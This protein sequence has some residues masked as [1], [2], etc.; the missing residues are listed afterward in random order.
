MDAADLITRLKVQGGLLS[1]WLR[2]VPRDELLWKP[3]PERWSMLEVLGHLLDEERDDFRTRIRLTLEGAAAWPH[4]DPEAWA[5]EHRYQDSNPG[6]TIDAFDRERA[7]SIAWLEELGDAGWSHSHEHPQLGRLAA[8]DL[9]AAWAAHDML[10]LQQ[11]ARLRVDW[12]QRS[13]EPYS[14]R[15]AAP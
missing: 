8:G 7:A 1:T 12:I 15:Y 6:R 14:I 2:S 4:I 5:G 10:H 3:A 11:L 13:A 9:L